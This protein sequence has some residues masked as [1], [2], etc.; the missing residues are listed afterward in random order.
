[1][2]LQQTNPSSPQREPLDWLFTAYFAN[3]DT[4]VQD[5]ADQSETKPGGS[6][7]TDVLAQPNLVAFEL[8]NVNGKESVLVDLI[9]GAFSVNG[10]PLIAHNQYFEPKVIPTRC[11]RINLLSRNSG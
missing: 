7:F 11:V 9:T 1:M 3:G 6:R 2:P 5:E 4:I 10:T 8:N